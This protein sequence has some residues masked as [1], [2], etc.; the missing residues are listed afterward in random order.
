MYLVGFSVPVGAFAAIRSDGSVVVWGSPMFGGDAAH[1][2]DQLKNVHHIQ[3][4]D[5]AFAAIL[6]DGSVVSWGDPEGAA[7]GDAD[8]GGDSSAVQSQLTGVQ[9]RSPV[10]PFS[11][12]LVQGSLP[13]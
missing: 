7:W 9:L 5:S 10:A 12:F 4:T 3:A 13:K 2:Q 11:L 1:V 8:A 6:H